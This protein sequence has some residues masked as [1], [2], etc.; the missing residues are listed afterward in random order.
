MG[1]VLV[2]GCSSGFGLETALAFGRRGVSV[3]AGLR[4]L[5]KAEALEE[6]ARSEGLSIE[7]LAL[8][9]DDRHSV[10]T[11]VTAALDRHGAI[12]VLVNNA[13]IG[14]VG[15]LEETPELVY[16]RIFETNVFGVLSLSQAVLPAMREA[17]SGVIVNVGSIQ[18][19]VP[20]P[21]FPIYGATKAALE[22]LTESLHYEIEPF[23]LRAVIVQP[24]RFATSFVENLVSERTQ[25]SPYESL[26]K[27][28]LAGWS[29]IPGRENPPPA[30]LV[31]DAVIRAATDPECPRHLPVGPDVESLAERRRALDDSRF[32]AYLR[33]ITGYGSG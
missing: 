8:D 30:S 10:V 23:G 13:G 22:S 31:A 21:F 33:Q 15:S 11:A 2:S 17:R 20:V 12:D 18:G 16:R 28:W 3:V 5:A 24:G 26:R 9:V 27:T 14:G 1:C 29:G 7:P 32:E 4:N 6:L 19:L 25:D